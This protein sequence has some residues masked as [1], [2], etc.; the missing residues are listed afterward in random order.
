[1]NIILVE[2][3]YF[4]KPNDYDTEHDFYWYILND[5]SGKLPGMGGVFNAVNLDVY[6][7]A[8]NN[9]IRYIDPDGNLILLGCS[10]KNNNGEQ[11]VQSMMNWASDQGIELDNRSK[12]ELTRIGNNL[13]MVGDAKKFLFIASIYAAALDSL[14]NGS[15]VNDK[16]IALSNIA[17]LTSE[18]LSEEIA[19]A[20][21]AMDYKQLGIIA[22]GINLV[23]A[24]ILEQNAN[25]LSFD[26]D[27]Q[28][29]QDLSKFWGKVADIMGNI[30]Y[31]S[32]Q[33]IVDTTNSKNK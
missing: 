28:G 18:V 6:C 33:S 15:D 32:A 24:D 31:D 4:P 19:T 30:R 11:F 12:E 25:I 27:M 16:I 14:S 2:G 9:P 29:N 20:L 17:G 7:Y 13:N 26:Y 22:K 10:G 23:V 3:K 8:A 21:G 5:A 1:M